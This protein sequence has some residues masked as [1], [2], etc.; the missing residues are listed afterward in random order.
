MRQTRYPYA[1][2]LPREIPILLSI[3]ALNHGIELMLNRAR[4]TARSEQLAQQTHDLRKRVESDLQH[5]GS[6]TR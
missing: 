4:P 5:A 6:V 3:A 1:P 2:L